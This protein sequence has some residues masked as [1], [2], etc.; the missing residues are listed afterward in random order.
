MEEGQKQSVRHEKRL[1]DKYAGRRNAGSGSFWSRK[2]DVRS[3][4]FIIEHKFTGGKSISIKGSWLKDLVRIGLME[5]KVP[6]LAFHLEGR[7]YV[8]LTEDDFDELL[9]RGDVGLGGE[10]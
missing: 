2:A 7:N 3:D 10:G 1:A 6:V 9:E 8:V 5:R 4:R